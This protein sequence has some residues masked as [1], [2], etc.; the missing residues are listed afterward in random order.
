[1]NH[2]NLVAVWAKLLSGSP[3]RLIV[4]EH[5]TL[6]Q[7]TQNDD[8][9][10]TRL[11]PQLIRRS[12]PRADGIVAVSRGVADDLAR[13]AGLCRRSIDVVYNPVVTP[14]LKREME[15]PV[16]HPWFRRGEPPVVLGVGRLSRQKDFP[17]LV[18]AFAAVRRHRP[19]RLMILGEGPERSRLENLIVELGIGEDVA[20]PGWVAG[21]PS[22]MAHA[23][24]FVLS[25]RWEGLPTVI[26]EA[27]Y[28][29]V[30][31]VATD[32]PSGPS[33]ILDGGRHG[34]LIPVGDRGALANAIG[35]ALA[36]NVH[37]PPP[38]SWQRYDLNRVVDQ[39]LAIFQGA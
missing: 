26:I 32:C 19:A 22:Y 14:K 34:E 16:S 29:G 31:V 27:L 21:A 38:E 10:R 23:A 25:S 7:E 18:H 20:L 28:A 3:T 24:T 39:Y 6:S 1:M 13:T 12:Y 4:S 30:P 9:W 33:E 36:G 11:L 15:A 2:A 37:R 35:A 17:T 5:N 8:K